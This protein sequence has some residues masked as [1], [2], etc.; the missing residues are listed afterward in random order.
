VQTTRPSL[1]NPAETPLYIVGVVINALIIGAILSSYWWLEELPARFS[2][3]VQGQVI[4]YVMYSLLLLMP[5]IV[6]GRQVQRASILGQAIRLSREQFPDIYAV[7]DE[8]ARQLNLPRNPE[9]YLANGNGTLNAFASSSVGRDYLV[10]SNELFAN[11]YNS[12][13]EG[14][15]FI[16]GHELGH[17]KRNHTKIWYQLTIL[18]FGILPIIS[19]FLSRAR[20]YT[21]DRFGAFLSPN[22]VDGLVLLA[23]GRYAYQR[24]D[25]AEVLTQE[26]QVRGVWAGVATLVRSHPLTIRR[27]KTLVDLGLISPER[28][29]DVP[30]AHQ[31]ILPAID[32]WE[33]STSLPR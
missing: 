15:A 29:T 2:E 7:K 25:V 24:V 1:V 31:V 21:C 4:Q 20:E 5:A 11:L 13:H 16:I 22:G 3:G 9:I 30:L 6:I 18:F 23:S 17:I 27:I 28:P 32:A 19:F 8:F 12:N 26:R 14:L 33:P 10:I